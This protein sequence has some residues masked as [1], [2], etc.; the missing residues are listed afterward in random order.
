[1]EG[2]DEEKVQK[3]IKNDP[4]FATYNPRRRGAGVLSGMKFMNMI[5][6]T[7]G[8]LSLGKLL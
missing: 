8:D 7:L 3:R 2:E 5:F 6:E 1:M 4:K